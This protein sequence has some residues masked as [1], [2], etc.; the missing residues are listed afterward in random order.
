LRTATLYHGR[1]NSGMKMELL[2]HVKSEIID[3]QK[4]GMYLPTLQCTPESDEK[5]RS[6]F[7][8]LSGDPEAWP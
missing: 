6:L 7:R 8:L 5:L 1:V 4:R 3:E 2:F